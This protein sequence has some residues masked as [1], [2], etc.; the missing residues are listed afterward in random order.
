MPPEPSTPTV[1]EIAGILTRMDIKPKVGFE[2]WELALIEARK[3][4]DAGKERRKKI[5]EILKM[6]ERKE[7]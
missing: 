4:V 6:H 7:I 5:A 2:I 1:E 3:W